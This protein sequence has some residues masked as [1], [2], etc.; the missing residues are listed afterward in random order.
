MTTSERPTHR[1]PIDARTLIA[2]AA[3]FAAMISFQLGASI[4]KGLFPMVGAQGATTLRQGFAAIML[5]VVMRPWRKPITRAGLPALL[6]YGVALGVMN[7]MFYMA[8]RTVPLGIAVTLEF[9][10][11][12]GVAACSLRRPADF[13]WIGLAVIGLLFLLPLRAAERGIDPLGAALALGAGGCW[14]LYI[15]FGQRAG[16][17]YGTQATA[18]GA[19]V[20]ALVAAPVGIAHAGWSLLDPAILPAALGLAALSSAVPYTLEMVALT[21]MP[22]RAYGTLTSV[23][24]AIGSLV[25]LVFLHEGLSLVQ[26]AAIGAIVLASIGTALTIQPP[27][28]IAPDADG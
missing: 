19:I 28:A 2:I 8:L 13:L 18:Y 11:P 20:A 6:L 3:L 17:Q 14:A 15:I 22:A 16:R 24:P 21:R 25:G 9:A 27:A 12:L 10:G 1:A 26:W 4:A 23:E 7:L 5:A